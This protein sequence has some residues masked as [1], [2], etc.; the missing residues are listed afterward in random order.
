MKLILTFL[1]IALFCQFLP[2]Q[3]IDSKLSDVKGD[4]TKITINT[5]EGE[6]SFEGE[7]AEH[8]FNKLKSSGSN[9]VWHS[10]DDDGKKKVVVIDSDGTGQSVEIFGDE[11][12]EELIIIS[13]DFDKDIDGIKKKIKVEMNDEN[14]K[15]TVTTNENGEEKTEV[16]EGDE[17]D[18][19]LE[20]MKEKH[21]GDMEF[22]IEM[23]D[24]G[25]VK[26]KKIIIE[27]ES[28]REPE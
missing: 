23:D 28:E 2:A 22:F 17:A 13:D 21:G 27:K 25:N 7:D 4:V 8:L 6:Y 19:Y 5:D 20:E 9:F 10:S 11:D 18:K 15:V 1:S 24:E 26:K 12:D 16:Y 14:K 3:D